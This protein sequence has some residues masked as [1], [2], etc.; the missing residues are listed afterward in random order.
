MLE[1]SYDRNDYNITCLN[2]TELISILN[3]IEP[4][5]N[6]TD[7][8]KNK[9][10]EKIKNLSPSSENDIIILENINE[11]TNKRYDNE[12]KTLI[13]TAFKPPKP[14]NEPK[15]WLLTNIEI[16]QV[17]SSYAKKFKRSKLFKSW[18]VDF[19]TTN[20]Q[21]YVFPL[22]KDLPEKYDNLCFIYN[23]D[24]YPNSG[25]HWI[26][27][28]IN[29]KNDKTIEHYDSFGKN[30]KKEIINYSN[31]L[32]NIYGKFNLKIYS[33]KQQNSSTN[34]CGIYALY[35]IKQ[36]LEGETFES[37]SRKIIPSDLMMNFRNYFFR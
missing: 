25:I 32:Q 9:L 17:L 22:T 29:L 2:E 28:F 31:L 18:Y 20:K 19:I 14:K 6:F 13:N 15:D 4:E 12:F 37:L 7:L 8:S 33:V 30:P 26:A 11:I 35:F 24:Y 27:V 34:V 36:R 1:C 5:K 16:D 21:E 10:H 23:T 3:F